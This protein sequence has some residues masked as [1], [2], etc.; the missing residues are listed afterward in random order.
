MSLIKKYAIFVSLLCSIVSFVFIANEFR[1]F[2]YLKTVSKTSTL[3][4]DDYIDPSKIEYSFPE[5]KRNI[6]YI[7]L[8]SVEISE[9]SKEEGGYFDNDF[10]P[11]L[12]QLAEENITFNNNK[13]YCVAP[14]TSW[15]VSSMVAQGSGIPLTIPI[16]ENDFVTSNKYLPGAYSM[17]EIFKQGGYTNEL[18]IGSEAVFS[19][20][21][22]YYEMHGDYIIHDFTYFVEN[23]L[24][25]Y[26][27]RVW[28][29]IVDR[30]LFEYAKEDLLELS[31]NNQP[32]NLTM[33]TVDTHHND[34][35]VCEDCED[36][37]EY[38]L[39]NVYACSSKRVR[40][41]VEWCKQQDFYENTTIV[42]A[43]DHNSMSPTFKEV[44]KDYD[45][46][47]YYTIINPYPGLEPTT[48]RQLCAFDLLPT[49]VASLGIE[50]EGNRLGLGSNLFSNEK[51]LIEKY[52]EFAF[53]ERLKERS[54]YYENHILYGF[55]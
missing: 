30:Y 38:Q 17:G 5:N 23:D 46:K 33:L 19:G 9:Y 40:E 55:G 43:G 41:F 18:L 32:F 48:N 10:I 20:R 15:T 6:I 22:Y 37:F 36:K 2:E 7:I 29:G 14:N 35:W 3:Y 50:F 4:E 24:F 52:G 45:R 21:K 49:T 47:V 13:G 1:L 53:F 51:T 16:G 8:E 11:E 39:A 25:D 44:I 42:I 27:T 12:H 34:G 54:A 28:W 26:D 31:K